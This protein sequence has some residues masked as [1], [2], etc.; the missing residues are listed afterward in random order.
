MP[1]IYISRSG[2][3]NKELDAKFTSTEIET[4][5]DDLSKLQQQNKIKEDRITTLQSEI[6]KMQRNLAMVTEVL[7]MQ[8]TESQIQKALKRKRNNLGLP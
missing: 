1:D 2:M 3:Q 8:P 4:L 7:E 6:E 5:K